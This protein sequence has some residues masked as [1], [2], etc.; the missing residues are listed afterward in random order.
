[1][2]FCFIKNANTNTKECTNE[3]TVWK[4]GNYEI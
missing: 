1:M 3:R 4:T 2:A